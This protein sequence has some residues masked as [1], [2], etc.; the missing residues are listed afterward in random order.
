[1]MTVGGFHIGDRSSPVAEDFYCS[2]RDLTS[3]RPQ[4]EPSGPG[5]AGRRVQLHSWTNALYRRGAW[6]RQHTPLAW[7]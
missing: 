4:T 2:A 6:R 5:G 3:A 1:M 7:C